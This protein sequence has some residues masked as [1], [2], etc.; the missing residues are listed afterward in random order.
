MWK[1]I[2]DA[3]KIKEIRNGLLF[4]LFIIV[5]VRLGS[6][7]PTPGINVELLQE[8]LNN[9]LGGQASGLLDSFTG[10]SFS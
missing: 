4:T 8:Y 3:F 9:N 5:I 7:I 1:T 10:G 6:Q 2:R